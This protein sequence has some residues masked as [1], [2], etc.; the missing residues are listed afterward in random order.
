MQKTTKYVIFRTNWGYFGL[1]GT[2][3]ALCRTYLPRP[4]LEKLKSHLL[5]DL[6]FEHRVP[7]IQHRA[8]LVRRSFSEGGSIEFDKAFFKAIQQQIIAY[9]KGVCVNFGLDIPVMLDGFSEFQRAVLTACRNVK[10]GQTITYGE[11]AKRSGRPAAARAVGNAIAKNPLPLI[12]PC[13]RVIRRDGSLGGFSGIG[14]LSLKKKLLLHEQNRLSA[15]HNF[16]S[17]E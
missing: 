15:T 13:H 16:T 10:F 1:A 7:S 9:F 8:S 3:Y 4:S 12:I 2:E 6:S 11:L 5:K 14:G 17:R